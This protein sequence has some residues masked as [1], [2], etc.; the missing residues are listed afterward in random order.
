MSQL[1]PSNVNTQVSHVFGLSQEVRVLSEQMYQGNESNVVNAEV[2][3]VFG[4][5]QG[6]PSLSRN[7]NASSSHFRHLTTMGRIGTSNIKHSNLVC[8]MT[9]EESHIN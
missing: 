4:C 6:N 2:S 8:T 7:Q 9:G 1:N 3:R 5:S